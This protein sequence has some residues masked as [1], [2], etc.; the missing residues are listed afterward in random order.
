MTLF[1]AINPFPLILNQTGSGLNGGSVYIGQ[2]NQDPETHPKNAYWDEAGTDLAFQ[3]LVTIG[4][5]IWNAGTPAQI[6][7]E[8]TYSIR[9]R[10]RFGAQIFYLPEVLE[11]LADFIARMVSTLGATLIGYDATSFSSAPSNSVATKLSQFLNPVDYPWS[12]SP[13]GAVDCAAA[14]MAAD[15]VAVAAGKPLYITGAH[16]VSS[17]ITLNADLIFI[18]GSLRPDSGKTITLRGSVQAGLYQI[19]GSG[20]SVAGAVVGVRS[21]WPEWFGAKRDGATDDANAIQRCNFCLMSSNPSDGIR[22]TINLADGVYGVGKTVRITPTNDINIAIVGAGGGESGTILYGLQSFSTSNGVAVLQIDG[23]LKSDGSARDAAYSIGGFRVKRHAS[24]AATTGFWIGPDEGT[25]KS[26]DGFH[27]SLI[28][29]VNV[30]DFPVGWRF[31]VMRLL[32]IERSSSWAEGVTGAICVLITAKGNGTP[33]TGDL[34]FENFQTVCDYADGST[35]F[36]I[37]AASNEQVRGIRWDRCI[38]YHGQIHVDIIHS[39]SS[40]MGDFWW[41]E[42]CQFDGVSGNIFNVQVASGSIF[43]NIWVQGTYT[44]GL[45]TNGFFWKCVNSGGRVNSIKISNNL[46]ED[47]DTGSTPLID[48]QGAAADID[49]S[50]NSFPNI[51]ST[52]YL[53]RFPGTAELLTVCDNKAF[54]LGTRTAVGMVQFS[55]TANRYSATGNIGSSGVWTGS[56]VSELNGTAT[57]Y[58]EGNI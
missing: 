11:A 37:T 49:I 46:V 33:F 20:G 14:L 56:V 18:G 51:A 25:E 4:G 36:R 32:K 35:N 47:A 7:V 50:H 38:S 31:N 8:G 3:P 5:Y 15:A 1:S 13:G 29:D 23:Q 55:A 58:V 34:D 27:E 16:R 19:F 40:D 30:F 54:K 10:D 26:L 28:H 43:D 9:V 57:K 48:F 21:V 6:Y 12:A 24:S 17:D 45:S 2:P 52:T 53:V 41:K 39:S 22:P 42:G 44:R